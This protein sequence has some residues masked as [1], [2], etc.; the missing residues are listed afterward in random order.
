MKAELGKLTTQARQLYSQLQPMQGQLRSFHQMHTSIG[1][2]EEAVHQLERVADEIQK[3]VMDTRMVPIGP[4]FTRFHRVI[5]DITRSSG[6]NI[7]LVLRGEKTELDKRM[8]DELGDPLI[9]MV[10]NSADHGIEPPEVRARS[11]KPAKGTITLDACHRGNSIL[12]QISDDGKGLNPESILRKAIEKG[13]ISKDDAERMSAHQIYQLIWEPGFSTAECVTDVSGRGIG[14]DI[15]K[16]KVESLN[17]TVDVESTPGQGTVI[18][19]K[20]PL[21][22]AILPSLMI[23][24]DDDVFAMP[25]ESVSEIIRVRSDEVSTVQGKDAVQVRGRVISMI[26]LG[27]VFE[28]A[29]ENRPASGQ[30]PIQ[31]TIV[32]V[33]E[34]DEEIGLVVDKV[35]GEEDVV[36]K[37]MSDNYKNVPGIAGASVLGNGRVSLILDPAGVIGMA[38]RRHAKA[39]IS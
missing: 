27:E 22:L 32:I 8:I 5:R 6:K 16:S 21:T 4:L 9:H 29:G 13:V 20:L 24:V 38:L 1:E 25:M 18:T 34:G 7:Q 2:L 26:R 11:G 31:R 19:M 17:G 36:I 35:I 15:V 33:N 37:S 12:I 39:T 10:R 3:N 14:M 28:W 30:E 23:E